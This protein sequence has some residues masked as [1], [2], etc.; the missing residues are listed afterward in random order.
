MSHPDFIEATRV[1]DVGSDL[2]CPSCITDQ[3]PGAGTVAAAMRAGRWGTADTINRSLQAFPV[4]PHAF[5]NACLALPL[6]SQYA[7]AHGRDHSRPSDNPIEAK[8]RTL[9]LLLLK[10]HVTTFLRRLHHQCEHF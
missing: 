6:V 2:A 3:V 1:F 4:F 7:K 5:A 8:R 10:R 9:A